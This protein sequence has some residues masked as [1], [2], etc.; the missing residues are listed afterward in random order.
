MSDHR[1]FATSALALLVCGLALWAWTRGDPSPGSPNH[2]EPPPHAVESSTSRTGAGEPS[3]AVRTAAAESPGAVAPGPTRTLTITTVDEN[4]AGVAA[5]SISAGTKL[6]ART[7]GAGTA[8]I[9][10]AALSYDAQGFAGLTF[11]H[12]S[13]T[14][15]PRS[16]TADMR[17]LVVAM[18]PA[19]QI[20]LRVVDEAGHAVP[21]AR[22]E[23][24]RASDRGLFHAVA[25]SWSTDALGSLVLVGAGQELMQ[26]RITADGFAPKDVEVAPVAGATS[27]VVVPLNL[28]TILAVTVLDPDA[29]PVAGAQ[30]T[31]FDALRRWDG[32]EW[33]AQ[34]DAR[35]KATLA[36]LPPGLESVQVVAAH[37]NHQ[38]TERTVPLDSEAPTEVEL[39]LQRAGMLRVRVLDPSGPA[40][41][42]RVA[43]RDPDLT[44][45]RYRA[46]AA[47]AADG[48]A[49]LGGIPGGMSLAVQVVQGHSVV[50]VRTGVGIAAG[51]TRELT[52]EIPA[53]IAVAFELRDQAGRRLTG[54]VYLDNRDGR[55]GPALQPLGSVIDL[56]LRYALRAE[57]D[58]AAVAHI[59]PGRYQIR[60]QIPAG[61]WFDLPERSLHEAA[62][63][64]LEVGTAK[65]LT[66]T[67]TDENGRGL[68]G[69]LVELRGFPN[70]PLAPTDAGGRFHFRHLGDGNGTLAVLDPYAGSVLLQ[71][72]V[73][74]G[75]DVTLVFR[76]TSLQGFVREFDGAA[77]PTARI[78]VVRIDAGAIHGLR[79][80]RDPRLHQPPTTDPEGRFELRLPAG[81]YELRARAGD[82]VAF[83]PSVVVGENPT[84]P[85]EL[86]AFQ[87]AS[88]EFGIPPT[89]AGLDRLTITVRGSRD[90]WSRELAAPSAADRTAWRIE[91]PP[92][93]LSFVVTAADGTI[94][95]TGSFR[96]ARGATG[97]LY[98]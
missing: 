40:S 48:T 37:P 56:P 59:V 36:S 89:D 63:V 28:A 12:D 68:A 14:A 31:V 30:L 77:V 95:H 19:G 96:L 79:R 49:L 74:A 65:S 76:R 43:A 70:T 61:T 6:L 5:V 39:R 82:R 3:A 90:E 73:G 57:L 71:D 7:D 66:G 94:T 29:Q 92:G 8:Q 51:E 10:L 84:Q 83:A 23:R 64:P 26:L 58:R 85:I 33:K 55:T 60:V 20:S 18:R 91:V 67:L 54:E 88:I 1:A 53:T 34:T 16:V 81:T 50:A 27:E 42:V 87:P 13:L 35:G 86:L 38:Q 41:D 32:Y 21:N 80:T 24:R 93:A 69:E 22:V 72:G 97:R 62:T 25:N 52:I 98:Q 11:S 2:R 46:E 78:D 75:A 15:S 45:D 17:D 4:A 9:D 44:Q 47:I